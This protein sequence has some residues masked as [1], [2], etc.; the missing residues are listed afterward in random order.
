MSKSYF[1]ILLFLASKVFCQTGSVNYHSDIEP[2]IRKYCLHCH[3]K[4]N[5]TTMALDSYKNVVSYAKM[6]EYVISNKT[7]PPFSV[8]LE[9]SK[10]NNIDQLSE[11]EI[12]IFK[13]WIQNKFEKGNAISAKLLESTADS[14]SYDRTFA[15][16][17]SYTN[18]GAYEEESRVFVIETNLSSDLE[19]D[20]LEFVPQNKNNIKSCNISIDTSSTSS[21]YDSYDLD[22]GYGTISGLSF[23][24]FQYNW[25]QWTMGD[26]AKYLK[27]GYFKTIPK[28]S[29]ILFQITYLP[30]LYPQK[31]SS[32]LRVRTVK[33]SEKLKPINS[34]FIL[35]NSNL[36]NK[37]FEINRYEK[38]KYAASY[39][40]EKPLEILSIMPQGMYA[41]KSWEIYAVNNN[42]QKINI[43][44]IPVWDY[45]WKKKYDLAEPKYLEKG[46]KIIAIAEYDNSETNENLPLLPPTKIKY[47]EGF[48]EELFLVQFDVSYF[49]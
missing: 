43:L 37:F 7:M 8:D 30:G 17:K 9:Y 34:N 26:K 16:K 6:I 45:H 28:N 23:I 40:L 1:L 41:C 36:P 5:T 48:R 21:E 42:N 47:G 39:I 2:I 49:Y 20:V 24:P 19:I 14:I 13:N 27:S 11:K 10:M 4:S 15:M 22:Y 44:K 25:Y 18:K 32:F 3:E 38:R 33:N 35:D 46:T 31:D 12:L 29:K